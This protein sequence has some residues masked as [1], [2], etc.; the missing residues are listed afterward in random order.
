MLSDSDLDASTSELQA[1]IS[2]VL[3]SA[4]VARDVQEQKVYS[5]ADRDVIPPRPIGR[6]LPVSPPPGIA[7]TMTGRLEIV[8]DRSGRVESVKLYTPH[9]GFHDRMIVSAAKAWHYR[10]A[11]RNGRPVRFSIV[12]PI[13]LPE[14]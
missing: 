10:P 9:N 12:V 7:P 14:S 1:S 8:V 13:N 4:R 2:T 3:S 5:I 6:Q 11:T